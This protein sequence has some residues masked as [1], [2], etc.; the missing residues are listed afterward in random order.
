LPIQTNAFP[1]SSRVGKSE[2]LPTQFPHHLSLMEWW[3]KCRVSSVSPLSS[4]D[5]I[6][7]TLLCSLIKLY[8]IK[9]CPKYCR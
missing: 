7:P 8:V 9:N 4:V 5:G 1:K 3:A 6:S 2:A